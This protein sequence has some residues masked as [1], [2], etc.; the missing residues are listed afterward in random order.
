MSLYKFN[1]IQIEKTA[2]VSLEVGKATLLATFIGIVIPGVGE[3]V[4][5]LGAIIGFGVFIGCYLFAMWLLR[6]VK[7]K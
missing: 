5:L 2:D 1:Q 6:E 3:R 7:K 4:G